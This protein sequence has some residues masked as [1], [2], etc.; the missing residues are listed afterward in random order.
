MRTSLWQRLLPFLT[1]IALFVGL[2]IATPN[3][4][5]RRIYR[6]WCGKQP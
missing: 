1:L 2:I 5:P 6:V 4:L 3:F